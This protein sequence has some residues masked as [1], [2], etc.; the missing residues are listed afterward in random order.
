LRL[1]RIER[2]Q[3]FGGAKGQV[4][5]PRAGWGTNRVG[6]AVIGATSVRFAN[7]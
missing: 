4:T 6:N 7:G 3:I 5:Q 2:R 1:L